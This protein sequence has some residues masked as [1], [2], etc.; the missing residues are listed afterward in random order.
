MLAQTIFAITNIAGAENI[1]L[2]TPARVKHTTMAETQR[3]SAT[4]KLRVCAAN[5]PR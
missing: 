4:A 1:I 2:N 3:S 5:Q